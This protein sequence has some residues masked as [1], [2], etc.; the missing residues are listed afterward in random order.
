MIGKDRKLLARMTS[1]NGAMGEVLVAMLAHQD[2]GELNAAD[3]RAVGERLRQLG[4]DMRDRADE[5]ERHP[6]ID[7]PWFDP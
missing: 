1:V 7:N 6:V 4:Q 2:G 3:L 5:L